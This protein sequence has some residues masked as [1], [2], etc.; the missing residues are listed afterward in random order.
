[1]QVEEWEPKVASEFGD[2]SIRFL[3]D[4]RN[5]SMHYSIPPV[6][7]TTRWH[8]LGGGPTEWQNI[9]ALKREE[10]LKYSRWSGAARR[11]ISTHDGDIEFWPVVAA[12]ST[13]VR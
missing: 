10:L 13:R 8:A 9:V 7:L 6:T 1:G 11:F 12:Y 2:D 4:L 5:F 3:V